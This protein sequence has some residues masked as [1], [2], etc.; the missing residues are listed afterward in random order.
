LL[1]RR[2]NRGSRARG[3]SLLIVMMLVAVLVGGAAIL[4]SSVQGQFQIAGQDRQAAAALYAADYAIAQGKAFI[5]SQPGL[6]V[7]SWNPLLTSTN[8]AV[9]KYLCFQPLPTPAARPGI[10]PKTVNPAIDLYSYP[11]GGKTQWNFCLH[12]NADDPAYIDSSVYSVAPGGVPQ[13]DTNDGLDPL[14][15]LVIEGYGS[16][17]ESNTATIPSAIAHVAVTITQPQLNGGGGFDSYAQVGAGA[18]HTGSS[19]AN[20]TGVAVGVGGTTF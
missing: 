11:Q 19:N 4:M 6:F 16:M 17:F 15:L 14:R 8:P 13:G 5:A 9:N 12:N 3:F 7:G 2:R 1:T 18:A 20:E 10:G